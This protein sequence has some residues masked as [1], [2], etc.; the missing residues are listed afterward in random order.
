[1]SKPAD[2]TAD[3]IKTVQPSYDGPE[4]DSVLTE[5]LSFL[6]P[7]KS[8]KAANPPA[9]KQ[10]A[11]QLS[12][13]QKLEAMDSKFDDNEED[14][15]SDEENVAAEE[16]NEEE[17][18]DDSADD[19]QQPDEEEG[20]DESDDDEE[21]EETVRNPKALFA[22]IQKV[23]SQRNAAR[24]A[25][26]EREKE[27]STLKTKFE[28]VAS[29]SIRHEPTADEPLGNI[30]SEKELDETE[31]Y[32]KQ[33]LKWCRENKTGGTR[34]TVNGKEK[35][36]D[37]EEVTARMDRALEIIQHAPARRRLLAAQQADVKTAAQT[38]PFFTPN[39]AL[40]QQFISF[41]DGVLYAGEG[42]NRRLRHQI[43]SLP[44][45]ATHLAERFLGKLARE[46]NYSIVP[47]ANGQVKLVPMKKAAPGAKKPEPTKPPVNLRPGNPPARKSSGRP[48]L[49]DAAASGDVDD[50]LSA[51]LGLLK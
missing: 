31:A 2:T 29:A 37:E 40:H 15:D 4:V 3:S 24:A 21:E 18:V 16:S 38:F 20:G 6:A 9:K 50:V 30:A 49:L 22:R 11:A 46:G 17:G 32:W 1:M 27:V 39:H 25:L 23:K 14:V 26:A 33:E 41:A 19:E 36:L 44:D 7:E 43:A 35:E 48:S 45:Y 12:V 42:D 47:T 51:E 28:E 13:R 8:G 5:E 34:K 10:T